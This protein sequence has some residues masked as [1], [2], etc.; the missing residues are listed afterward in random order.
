MSLSYTLDI[1]P[2]VGNVSDRI[3]FRTAKLIMYLTY[4]N[5]SDWLDLT[6]KC[7]LYTYAKAARNRVSSGLS[8][9]KVIKRQCSI[10]MFKLVTLLESI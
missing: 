2:H 4:V 1:Y 8:I 7:S 5:M 10:A 9:E 3:I 6:W